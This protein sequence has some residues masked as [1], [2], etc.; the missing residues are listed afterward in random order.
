MRTT[1]LISISILPELLAEAERLAQ[2]ENAPA[3][4]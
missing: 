2:E 3:A 1:K 4:N